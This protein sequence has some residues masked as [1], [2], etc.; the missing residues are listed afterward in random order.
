[1]LAV[2]FCGFS[3]NNIA[4]MNA[5]EL[6]PAFEK[7]PN[8]SSKST[9]FNF[10]SG[11]IMVNA[12]VDGELGEFILDTGAP[13]LI[14]NSKE[15]T[16]TTLLAS[17]VNSSISIGE[18]T[19]ENFEWGGFEKHNV[20]G[21][22]LDISH[23]SRGEEASPDGLIGYQ[24]LK[25]NAVLVDFEN[26]EIAVLSKKDLK[27]KIKSSENVVTIPFVTEGHLPIL[28]LKIDGKTYRFGLDTGAEKNLLNKD[29]FEK[30]S[31]ENV[32]YELMQGLDGGIRKVAIGEVKNLKS[33]KYEIEK[34]KF[35]YSD[36]SGV[37]S[38]EFGYQIDGL[39]GLPFFQNKTF[40]IDYRKGQ[41][42]IWQ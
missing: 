5:A 13:G 23:M 32:K 8:L 6:S 11:L 38:G 2:G 34:M 20:E 19:V 1:M 30:T 27:K 14:I 36:L 15:N 29:L 12:L 39:L 21:Y 17:S 33:K 42:H 10:S 26:T 18:I 3:Q 40:V 24:I 16:E 25:N 37:T 35:L 31:P 22:T 28:K 9:N 4:Y 41:L 7:T